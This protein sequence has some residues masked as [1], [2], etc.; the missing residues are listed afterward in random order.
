MNFGPALREPAATLDEIESY[1]LIYVSIAAHASSKDEL[2]ELL[3]ISRK[4]NSAAGITG[5]A[6]G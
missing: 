6:L 2:V 3:K 4:N 1:F 5:D